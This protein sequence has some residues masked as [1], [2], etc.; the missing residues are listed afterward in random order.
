[1]IL[2]ICSKRGS[3]SVFLMVILAGILLVT[4]LFIHEA[5]KI[6]GGSYTDAVLELSG[7]S[8]LSEYD[9]PLLEQYG[10]F[11]FRAEKI[12]VEDKLRHYADYSFQNN[13]LKEMTRIKRYLDP[14][15]LDIDS[16]QADLKGYSI[17]NTE[18]FEKQVV[19]YMKTGIIKNLPDGNKNIAAK[20]LNIELKN[21]QVINSLPSN[22]Y[23]KKSLDITQLIAE[24]IPSIQEIRNSGSK[25]FLINEYI[26][27]N[28]FN[29]RKG[30]EIRDTF[31]INEVEYILNGG[32]NDQNNYKDVRR[33]LILMRI[34][35]NSLHIFGDSIKRNEVTALASIITPG[36]GMLVT[37]ALITAAWAAA[38][39]ENDIRR[40]EDGKEVALIK[41][42]DQWALDLKRAVKYNKKTPNDIKPK[43]NN[44]GYTEPAV[45][46]GNDYEDYLRILLFLE[47]REIKLLRCMDLIQLNMKGTYRKD[48]DLKEYYGGFQFEAVVQNKKYS[49]IQKY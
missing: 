46:N 13:Y 23:S 14:L 1:M 25:N 33:D 15:K 5:A 7:R 27:C 40:L 43:K 28:F 37:E 44:G 42:R 9:L 18:L 12:Q 8:I 17:T 41:A 26:M 16:I 4:S 20:E 32:L 36:P 29:N 47:N 11:A 48:F 39:A 21:Q 38:E 22:G 31:F 34:G 19:E 10:I 45:N 35:L 3:T 6:A 49:Y 24:G 30:K 2:F